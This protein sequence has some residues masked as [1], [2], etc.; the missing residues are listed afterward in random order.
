MQHPWR[1]LLK[2]REG[3]AGKAV[4]LVAS[5]GNIDIEVYRRVLAGD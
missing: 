3:M 4:G 1:R 5:G 2:E